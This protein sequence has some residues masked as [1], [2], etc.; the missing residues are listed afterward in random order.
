MHEKQVE[1]AYLEARERYSALGVDTEKA[2]AQMREIPVGMH[3]WQVD[4]VA[5]FE[6]KEEGLEGA[7][8]MATGN[9]PGRATTPE[10]AR[11]DYQMVM[12]LVPGPLRLS[13]HACYAET[14]GKRVD[15]DELAPEHFAS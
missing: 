9:Y 6:V 8:I 1:E 7:G 3:C 15:R 5:G 12:S 4:D 10:Q 11:A 14:G 2:I 13:L